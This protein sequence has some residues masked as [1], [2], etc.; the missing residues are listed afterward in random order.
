M[1]LVLHTCMY[2]SLSANK[3]RYDTISFTREDPLGW[4]GPRAVTTVS[5][6]S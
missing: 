5:A 2:S 4:A 3:L 1:K 6:I